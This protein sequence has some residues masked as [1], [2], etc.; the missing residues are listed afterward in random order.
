MKKTQTSKKNRN[1]AKL[2]ERDND[3]IKHEEFI[4]NSIQL[5]W[6]SRFRCF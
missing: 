5:R 2:I 4:V 6:K 1:W 3:K